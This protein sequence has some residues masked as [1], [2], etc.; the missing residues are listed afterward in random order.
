MRKTFNNAAKF[1]LHKYH[2]EKKKDEKPLL[3]LK[4]LAGTT[5]LFL[6]G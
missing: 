5:A 4:P 2:I 3:S 1:K 6:Q